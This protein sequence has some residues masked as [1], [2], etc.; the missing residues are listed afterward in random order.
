MNKK[1]FPF[2]NSKKRFFFINIKHKNPNVS[3]KREY[4]LSKYDALYDTQLFFLKNFINSNKIENDDLGFNLENKKTPIFKSDYKIKSLELTL[5]KNLKFIWDNNETKKI[6]KLLI[7]KNII[8]KDELKKIT[9]INELGIYLFDLYFKKDKR[10]EKDFIYKLISEYF[11][12]IKF[13]IDFKILRDST[14]N[15]LLNTM[16]EIKNQNDVIYHD[17]I[18]S[19]FRKLRAKINHTIYIKNESM[20][21]LLN[22][23]EQW[24]ASKP[25]IILNASTNKKIKVINYLD[26]YELENLMYRNYTLKNSIKFNYNLS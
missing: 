22:H 13:E 26:F 14:K 16:I 18:E 3:K 1:F 21:K 25:E 23:W 19:F 17:K 5:N 2:F 7:K 11:P 8:E 15:F 24:I 10:S 12:S 20:D 6:M 9:F 4:N